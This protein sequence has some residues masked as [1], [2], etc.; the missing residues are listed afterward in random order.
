MKKKIFLLAW[1]MLSLV[2]WGL[3]TEFGYPVSGEPWYFIKVS[4][5]DPSLSPGG[6][7]GVSRVMVNNQRARDFVLFQGGEELPGKEIRA[8][9][10]F[11]LK[12][13]YPWEGGKTYEI[14]VQ[15]ENE[16]RKKSASLVQEVTSPARRGYWN[17]A[18][19]NHLTL[20]VSEEHGI[21]RE[22][23]PVHA[24]VGIL[25]AYFRSPNEV[26]VIKAEKGSNDVVYTEIPSQVY[27]VIRW[28]DPEVLSKVEIDEKT[29]Q[30]IVRYHPTTS[31]SVAFLAKLKPG[32]RASYLLFY[33]NPEAPPPGYV[34]D[35]RVAGTGIGKT[36]ENKHFRVTLHK[37]S[38]VIYE[39]T[40][41]SSKTRLE[42]KLETNGSIHWNPGVYSPPH[43][44]YHTSDWENPPYSEIEG[45]IFYSIRLAA[46][47]PFYPNV[48]AS[49]TY[50]F[51]AG[52]PFILVETT[53]HITDSLFVKALRNG[54]VVFNKKVF[55]KAAYPTMDG[56]V[57]VIDLNRTRMHPDHVIMLRPDV[58]WVTFYDEKK[59]VAFANLYLE[60]VATNLDGGE[61]STQQPYVYIQHGPWYYLARGLVYSFGSSNQ[62]RML[63][64]R[65]GSVYYEKNVFYPFAIGNG[66][67]FS[68]E[69]ARLFRMLKYPL[70]V[71]ESM[72]TY[73]ESPEGW[74]V[75]ILTEPFEE[76]VRE[77]I[78]GKKKKEEKRAS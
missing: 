54:E 61:A 56:E 42:H 67:S 5:A 64:A 34:T 7:W 50:R 29:G 69:S 13:R 46:P 70:S 59:A 8:E 24:T 73:A 68:E 27:E 40:E 63:P 17:P 3:T 72:E 28:E 55:T 52:T 25:S 9:H 41:K 26:R 47:I 11:E 35:L 21:E 43:A 31:F 37:K 20:L 51:Y 30:R 15:L 4:F 1:S 77:A 45:P 60:T 76:G 58:P 65:S 71:L 14:R 75:P 10:P 48:R 6:T 57:R 32:E 23:Y 12:I 39:I 53:I 49:V 18:W 62:T 38:G 74:I 66:Q 44:W 16:K 19:K 2:S 78:G 22:N 33:N 36:I